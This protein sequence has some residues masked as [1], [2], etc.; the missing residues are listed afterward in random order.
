MRDDVQ[1]RPRRAVRL[2]WRTSSDG[3]ADVAERVAVVAVVALAGALLAGS[4]IVMTGPT[5]DLEAAP[6]T[7]TSP[8]STSTVGGVD[9][10]LSGQSASVTI[11]EDRTLGVRQTF[12]WSGAAPV[13][14]VFTPPEL[15][16]VPGSGGA[17]PAVEEVTAT[18]D[19]TE[20]EVSKVGVSA[21]S[22]WAVAVAG[23]HGPGTLVLDF[24]VRSAVTASERSA[25]GRALAVIPLLSVADAE[26][27]ERPVDVASASVIN[28]VCPLSGGDVVLCGSRSDDGWVAVVPPREDLLLAQ[29]DF[30]SG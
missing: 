8:S 29:L 12:R 19:G 4:V 2:P 6:S 5:A 22:P 24:D 27:V 11:A 9:P 17:S 15:T 10:S 16:E 13:R 1:S 23:D 25:P 20:I 26:P 3:D 7:S 28:V 18:L 14:L 30:P 21:A